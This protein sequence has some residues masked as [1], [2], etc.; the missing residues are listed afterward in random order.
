MDQCVKVLVVEYITGGGMRTKALSE[1]LA[2]E[3]EMMLK[4]LLD[5]LLEIPQV[6]VIVPRDSRLGELRLDKDGNR[7]REVMVGDSGFRTLW[8]SL[9]SQCDAVWPVAPETTGI[10]EMLSADVEQAEKILLNTP[11]SAVREVSSKIDTLERLH[12]HGISVVPTY[13]LTD[14]KLDLCFPWVIK[15]D[16]GVGCEGIQIVRDSIQWKNLFQHNNENRIIQPLIAGEPMSL[17]LLC[18]DGKAEIL[19]WN[20]MNV[21]SID[22]G[23]YL[24]SCESSTTFD[25][26]NR[27]QELAN[28]V[29]ATFPGLWG[30]VGVDFLFADNQLLVLEV[31]PR[32]TTSY[33]GL[34]QTIGYNPAR[35]VLAMA[36]LLRENQKMGQKCQQM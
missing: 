7:I 9:V 26:E 5:D 21:E 14:N 2:L 36:G 27:F 28:G 8:L 24:R 32:L 6:T 1:G 29:A 11:S 15:P 4:A 30:Y 33:A 18:Q 34:S 23:F 20:R 25:K 35:K 31:N 19:S 10:L 17:S 22:D 3:G 16:D 12:A 13:R